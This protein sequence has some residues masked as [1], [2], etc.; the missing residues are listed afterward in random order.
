[1][2]MAL[3]VDDDEVF[4]SCLAEALGTAQNCCI[5]TAINGKEAEKIM[6]SFRMDFVI[7]DLNMP[8]MNGYEF[9]SHTRENYPDIPIV[10]MTGTKTPEVEERLRTL[11]VPQ[12]IE[13]PFNVT[14]MVP[15]IL[16]E[17]RENIGHDF[18]N[19]KL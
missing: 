12:C 5:V 4:C 17:L 6:E 13:K 9:I 14:E 16:K 18:T 3:V 7:T 11:G 2:K 1:M 15:L 19:Y 10:A 8:G